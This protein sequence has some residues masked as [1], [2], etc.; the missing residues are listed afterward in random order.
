M[1]RR[2][3]L[4]EERPILPVERVEEI[5]A[6]LERILS[7]H[8]FRG[9][10]RCLSLLRHIVERTLAGDSASLKERTLGVEVFGREPDY[11]TNQDPV[12]RATAAE[13]R[14]RLAQ[15]YQEPGDESEARIEL[16]SGSYVADFHFNGRGAARQRRKRYAAIAGV[17]AVILLLILT[18]GLVLQLRKQSPLDQLWSPLLQAPG[19]ALICV[20]Q[21]IVYNLKS[22][23]AQDAIQGILEAEPSAGSP[24]VNDIPR[25]DLLILSDRYVD[26][27]DAICLTHMTSLLERYGKP[28]RIRGEQ[29]TSFA[30]LSEGPAVLIGAFNN[31]WTLRAAGQLRFTFVK[32]SA[33]AIDMVRDRQH[34]ENTEWKLTGVWPNWDVPYDYAIVTRVLDTTSNRPV[35]IAAGITQHGTMAAG[36]FLSN[37]EYFSE[38]VPLLPAGWQKKNL[39]IVLR[40]PVVHRVAGRPRVL[41]THVW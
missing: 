10:R 21:P 14:K 26:L 40:V 22:I 20:G 29:T 5:R 7:S 13:I 32:D 25:K 36:A 3:D 28:F 8:H 4:R 33:R 11:D 31:Q 37:A 1:S 12:V 39:Q 15:Y 24:A 6:L 35:V 18:A 17:A 19:T 34:P 9:S 38:A 30:D 23:Q 41:V 27:G 16:L 2:P